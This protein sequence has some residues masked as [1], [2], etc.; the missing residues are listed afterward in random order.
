MQY[1][2]GQT[3]AELIRKESLNQVQMVSLAQQIA[4][5]LAE[6]HAHGIIHRDI[7]PRN[8]MVTP[9]E[10]VKVLD[11]GL[12]KTIHT[13]LE[14]ATESI[15]QLSKE[16][17]LVG[18]IAYM[19]P[20]QLRGERLDY[21]SDIFSLGTVL[22]E[23]VCGKNPFA[24][25]TESKS[26][27]NAEVISSIMSDEP[28]SLRQMSINCPRDFDQVVNKCLRKDPADRY[29]SAPELLIDLENLQKGFAL[30]SRNSSYLNVRSAAVA[31]VLLLAIFVVAYVASGW[32]TKGHTLAV[33]PIVCDEAVIPNQCLGP[34]M[35][36]GL[37]RMLSRRNGLRVTSSQT[38]PSL[39]GRFGQ[40]LGA[41]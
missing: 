40:V 29:Q 3:L 27:S 22:Y 24:L 11:F 18:T 31:A 41:H 25:K 12:A 38:A 36:E 33:L 4:Q 28:Q 8:I 20:E 37:V 34:S 26:R 35:T 19:S 23:M 39:L 30:P 15:S 16:G 1:V 14:D 21:R 17:L 6:A 9:S 2:E 7:K 13:S 32:K 10:Q 5:A